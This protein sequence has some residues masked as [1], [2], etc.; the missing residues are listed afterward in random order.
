MILEGEEG[1]KE[2]YQ[3]VMLKENDIPGILKLDVRY[4]DNKS[5]Y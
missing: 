3:V 1:E 4:L 5:Q 2:D